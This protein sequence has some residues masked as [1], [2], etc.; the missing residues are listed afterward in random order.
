MNPTDEVAISAMFAEAKTL[1]EMK[2]KTSEEYV[3]ERIRDYAL[4]VLKNQYRVKSELL[5]ALRKNRYVLGKDVELPAEG[6]INIKNDI[7]FGE[8]KIQIRCHLRNPS[9]HVVKSWYCSKGR[10][11][12]PSENIVF[13]NIWWHTSDTKDP[14]YS[15]CSAWRLDN[16]ACIDD[17]Y[18]RVISITKGIYE[19]IL[20]A[21]EHG[22]FTERQWQQIYG[23]ATWTEAY[24]KKLVACFK[25]FIENRVAMLRGS[26]NTD[27]EAKKK[28]ESSL[29]N[30]TRTTTINITWTI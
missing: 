10:I 26:V 5:D 6:F 24:T 23:Q 3:N 16:H 22:K 1:N 11:V 2:K 25:K 7:F 4:A 29:N 13:D 14:D 17:E 20:Q 21:I 28:N 19:D 9:N 18:G 27:L 30:G 12:T 8:C 15:I